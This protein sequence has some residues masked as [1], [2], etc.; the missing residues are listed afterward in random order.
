MHLCRLFLHVALQ[1][2]EGTAGFVGYWIFA[3]GRTIGRVTLALRFIEL[4]ERTNVT[5]RMTASA[6]PMSLIA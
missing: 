5:S 1:F 2:T 4:L 6:M 3:P